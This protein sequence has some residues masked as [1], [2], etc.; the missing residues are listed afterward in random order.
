MR[1]IR[2]CHDN[3]YARNFWQHFGRIISYHYWFHRIV[4]PVLTPTLTYRKNFHFFFRGE[5]VKKDANLE[6]NY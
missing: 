1:T 4:I 2:E 3:K 5:G 6:D